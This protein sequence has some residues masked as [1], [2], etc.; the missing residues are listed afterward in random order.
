MAGAWRL[1][2]GPLGDYWLWAFKNRALGPIK[3]DAGVLSFAPGMLSGLAALLVETPA[4]DALAPFAVAG[5]ILPMFNFL[6]T[7]VWF[8]KFR[9]GFEGISKKM[10]KP[11]VW[12]VVFYV[13]C[14]ASF[15]YWPSA[16]V[17]GS[18]R[19]EATWWAALCGVPLCVLIYVPALKVSAEKMNEWAG[20]KPMAAQ[21]LE[22]LESAVK[23]AGG[24][25]EVGVSAAPSAVGLEEVRG[26]ER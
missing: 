22:S 13:Y 3:T 26:G 18:V 2:G 14:C 11:Y 10:E 1:T 12:S 17:I 6:V 21:A 25:D 8:I 5:A 15:I 24:G 19:G 7:V 20:V 4:P 9:P 23:K 16:A